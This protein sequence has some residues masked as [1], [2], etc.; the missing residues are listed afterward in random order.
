MNSCRNNPNKN[1][2]RHGIVLLVTLVILVV[3]SMVGYTL[4]SR[5]IA[6]RL[7]S[8]YLVDYS[9]A[10]YG[11][12]SAL[13]YALANFQE[14]NPKLV[15]RPNE[16]D[17]SDLFALDADQYRQFV[18]QW[19]LQ[20]QFDNS[21]KSIFITNTSESTDSNNSGQV[22][23]N[24]LENI[25][26][27]GPYGAPWPLIEEPIEIDIGSAKVR[28]EIEDENAKY[29]LGW[30]ML[31]DKATQREIDAGFDTF[32]EMNGLKFEQIE[33]LKS[34]LAEI[35]KI[36][37]FKVT[38]QPEVITTRKPV[39]TTASSTTRGRTGTATA[40]Q[41]SRTVLT[42]ASQISSQTTSFVKLFNCNLLDKDTL[43]IPTIIDGKREESPLKYI[44]TW[45]TRLVNINTAPR[46]VLEAAFIFG[47]D[48]VEI[49]DQ[50][51]Q[52][53]K[54]QPFES[55]DDLQKRVVGY[56]EPIEKCKSYITTESRIFTIRITATSGLAKA[57]ALIAVSKDGKTVK[58]IAVI[59]S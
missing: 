46:H 19:K 5:V 33:A 38:F 48:Q 7:R 52:L 47:G 6:E 58:R 25:T 35:R 50:I 13:K 32:C 12:E 23:S 16:P 17:F 11:C 9:K 29:P 2:N 21:K 15:S 40:T 42:A 55:F 4:T 1:S 36:R 22:D 8:Q 24:D 57:Y 10:R 43:A 49:A 53:R 30:A 31:E 41:I 54:I 28:I 45:A 27:P 14:I 26:I 51:I 18:E 39:R 20:S 34:D 37:P 56:T 59:N 3:L 44:S